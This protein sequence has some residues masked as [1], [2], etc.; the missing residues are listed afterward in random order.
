MGLGTLRPPENHPEAEHHQTLIKIELPAQCEIRELA[1][2]L[3]LH[4]QTNVLLSSASRKLWKRSLAG[5]GG[6]SAEL[7]H[8][9]VPLGMYM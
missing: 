6:G 3:R 8:I 7:S 1:M 5:P 4:F 2:K 9:L